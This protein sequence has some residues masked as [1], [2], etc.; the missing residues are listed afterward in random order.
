MVYLKLE[1]DAKKA[2]L[3]AEAKVNEARLAAV[4]QA[5]G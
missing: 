3:E 2:A 1:A 4:A 5:E